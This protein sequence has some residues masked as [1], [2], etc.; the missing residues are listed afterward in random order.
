MTSPNEESLGLVSTNCDRDFVPRVSYRDDP[1]E[2]D[3]NDDDDDDDDH[4]RDERV[5]P[6]HARRETH[7]ASR[8]ST[9]WQ[10]LVCAARITIVV[11]I[12]GTLLVTGKSLF[13][14]GEIRDESGASAEH[15]VAAGSASPRDEIRAVQISNY[16]AGKA[17]LLNVHITH[18]AGTTFCDAMK[19]LGP[20]PAFACMRD[21]RDRDEWPPSLDHHRPWTRDETDGNAIALRKAYHFL[22][23]E[24]GILPP[25]PLK[26][27]DWES[28]HLVSVILMRDPLERRLAADATVEKYFGEEESR[29]EE[30]WW[31]FAEYEGSVNFVLTRLTPDR[32][33][34]KGEDTTEACLEEGK[35]LL[36]RFTYILDVQCLEEGIKALSSELGLPRPHVKKG[37]TND[38]LHQMTTRERIGNDEIYDFIV[39]RNRRDIELYEW[40]KGLSLVKCSELTSTPVD[41]DLLHVDDDADDLEIGNVSETEQP[42]SQPTPAKNPHEDT[43]KH[44]AIR[45]MQIHNY[46]LGR[47]L[48]LN[49]HITHH[50]GTTVCNAM[51][52]LGHAPEGACNRGDDWPETVPKYRPWGYDETDENAKAL[53]NVYHFISWEFGIIPPTPLKEVKW[54]SPNLVSFIVMKDPIDRRLSGDATTSKLFGEEADRTEEQ[55]EAFA[56]YDGSI[57]FMLT[58]LTPDHCGEEGENATIACLEHGKELL[59]RFTFILDI[60]CLEEGLEALANELGLPIPDVKKGRGR[61][62]M[63]ARERIGNDDIYDFIVGRNR[64]DLELYEWSK[65]LSL[66]DCSA[67]DE[68]DFDDDLNVADAGDV[69]QFSDAINY[70]YTLNAT[71]YSDDKFDAEDDSVFNNQS[72]SKSTN[73]ELG[74]EISLASNNITNQD[75]IN[76]DDRESIRALQ[77]ENYK[78]GNAL[79][80]NIHITHHAGTT[81]CAAMKHVGNTPEHACNNGDDWPDSVTQHRPWEYNETDR[82]AIELRKVY[83]FI[84]WEFGKKPRSPLV[85][86]NWESPHLVSVIVMKDPIDRRLSGD[87]GINRM[88]G[89]E[90]E[91]TEEQWEAFAKYDGSINFMLTRLTPDRCGTEG[92]NTTEECLETG[93]ELLRRFTY[94]LDVKCLDEGL[95]ALAGELGFSLP[96]L[97]KDSGK[98]QVSARERIGDDELYEFILRRNQRD[99]ELYEWSK[100]LSLVNCSALEE[101]LFD[102]DDD[103]NDIINNDD[104][105]NDSAGNDGNVL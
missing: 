45:A 55:W 6:L 84:S 52:Q 44:N 89:K 12:V 68:G 82:N 42:T 97:N 74:S 59:R 37:N 7:H 95:E 58:R 49:V 56:K 29:T 16:R 70:N 93:K 53:R 33:G 50:G 91:R 27:V 78:K 57:N 77:I 54:E 24:F 23:W 21:D 62:S 88:F 28:P 43:S 103:N 10:R 34:E 92:E 48:L 11:S 32:C 75:N 73:E 85:D 87:G 13:H 18:H 36:R 51:K 20:A 17:L 81:F 101:E 26:D 67:L 72:D 30:E 90:E 38:S 83:H 41:D 69:D 35:E 63:S 105:F 2:N 22:S 98:T 76:I 46:K 102:D 25:T 71:D 39:K 94:I 5:L 96:Y 86:V 80:L 3:H 4:D 8:S 60:Q 61:T 64:L 79:L 100:G 14:V 65:S 1:D 31:E 15:D 99:F 66:V 47:A 19:Q 104:D 9:P 40:S